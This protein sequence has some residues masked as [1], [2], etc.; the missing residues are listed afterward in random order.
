[1]TVED[2]LMSRIHDLEKALAQEQLRSA[3]LDGQV[4]ELMTERIAMARQYGKL[5]SRIAGLLRVM[6]EEVDR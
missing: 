6:L 3:E 4:R 5:Q 2:D 1:M